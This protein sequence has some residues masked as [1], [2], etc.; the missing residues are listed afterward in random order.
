MTKAIDVA[1][2]GATGEVGQ[3]LLEILHSRDLPVGKIYPLA[4][5]NSSGQEVSFGNKTL[6]VIDAATFDFNKVKL[7]F[8]SAGS[9]ASLKYAP[10]ASKA[11]CVVIDNT[12]AFRYDPNIPLIVPEVNAD[13]IQDIDFSDPKNRIIANPNCSTIQMLVA[14]KPIYD[15]VGI[16][17]INV[18][19]YQS[20][21]G[22][23]KR[24]ISELVE[25]TG[26]LLNAKF[27]EPEVYPKPIAFNLLPHIDAFQDNGYTKEEMKMVWETK[28]ILNDDKILV[29]PTAVRVPVIYSHSEAINI[30]TNSKLSLSDAYEV[31]KEAKGVI[32]ND[33]NSDYPYP[34]PR[35]V[36]GSDA[37]YIG[38]LREDISHPMALNMWVVADNIRK[39]AALNSIQ[40]AE[41]ILNKL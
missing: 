20:V 26:S 9:E 10:I 30:E 36:A 3:T 7:A 33:P 8:F 24:A 11:G 17:R 15:K 23:G 12:A 38:R 34:C 18:S 1:I 37:V 40:I 28:K 32:V 21:S 16:S 13:I 19:T 39:G 29:N 22:T 4:S 27:M 25:Q 5:Q 31:L 41:L 14:I 6:E 2:L 35:D